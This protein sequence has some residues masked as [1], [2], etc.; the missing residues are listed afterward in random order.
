MLG[1]ALVVY[2]KTACSKVPSRKNNCGA[3]GNKMGIPEV[4]SARIPLPHSV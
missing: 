2:E 3:G 4:V 1:Q